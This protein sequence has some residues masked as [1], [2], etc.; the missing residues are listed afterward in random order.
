MKKRWIGRGDIDFAKVTEDA[1]KYNISTAF[2]AIL[3]VRGLDYDALVNPGK[4]V[5]DSHL[6]K[7][8]DK[9]IAIVSD[10][11]NS[12]KTICVVNDYD[13]DGDTS[14]TIM[15]EGIEACGG[16][17]FIVTP[18][19][20]VDGYGISKRLVDLAK[21]KGAGLI[22][23]TD[24][25]IA[26]TEAISYA[27]D[28]GFTVVITDH[29]EVP[30]TS[31]GDEIL[32]PADAIID[33]KQK[34][35][36][37]PFKEICGAQVAFKF[38]ILLFKAYNIDKETMNRYMMRFTELAAVG[39]VCDVMPLTGENRGLVKAGL[40]LL[41]SSRVMGFRQLMK[42][43][44]IEPSKITAESIAFGIGPCMN[45]MSRLKDD[46]DT[47]LDFLS[48]K[49]Y[50]KAEKLAIC[51]NDTNEERKSIQEETLSQ[52][53]SILLL[54]GEKQ[55][56][57]LFI[58]NSNPAIMGIVAGKVREFT[59]HP[60]VCFT[61]GEGGI[62]VGSGRSTDN[63]DMFTMFSKHKDLYL[64]FGGHPGAIGISISEENLGKVMAL[65]NEDAKDYDFAIETVIDLAIAMN[66]VSEQFVEDINIMEPFGQGNPAP[67]LCDNTSIL[68]G[69]R[70]IGSEKQFIRLSFIDNLG[71]DFEAVYF[72]DASSFDSYIE[73]SFGKESLKNLYNCSGNAALDIIYTPKFN[74]W[75]GARTISYT[76]EDYKVRGE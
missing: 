6:F 2:A 19:R 34:D 27:K 67:V 71:Q 50:I 14:G 72:G 44:K 30:K 64:K 37:Y 38:I 1:Q 7:D 62:L 48:E 20:R 60:T 31:D 74:Y 5:H 55:I 17:A 21:D 28:L 68:T 56:N 51:L 39:T 70:R 32:P 41:R 15:K 57:F 49:D 24:N 65:I 52:A 54:E 4:T 11:I 36:K 75:N 25:G 3:Q 26:A 8:M 42:I 10:A 16:N 33:P 40:E 58:P 45:A 12:G 69:L 46:T 13:V 61:G 59:G 18:K 9:G 73:S 66:R 47:V 63:Y 22:I 35:C 29:H 23:T 43:K 76:I 53:K